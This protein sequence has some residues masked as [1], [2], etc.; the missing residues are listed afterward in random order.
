MLFRSQGRHCRIERRFICAADRDGTSREAAQ[1]RPRRAAYPRNPRPADTA[2]AC[3]ALR[4]LTP[5]R[6]SRTPACPARPQPG[7]P[8]LRAPPGPAPARSPP[9]CTA[10]PG[11]RAGT[12]QLH[13]L[14]P[15]APA[16][17]R[18]EAE[19]KAATISAYLAA[20][21][22]SRAGYAARPRTLAQITL[23]R[24]RPGQWRRA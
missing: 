17:A 24:R 11:L 9:L 5:S 15:A 2:R 4:R 1:P 13:G 12:W 20:E 21:A 14:H 7:W 8:A 10:R 18:A 22:A 23:D 16:P 3:H 19:D 6:S